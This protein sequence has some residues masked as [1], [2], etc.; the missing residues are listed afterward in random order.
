MN[1]YQK[2]KSNIVNTLVRVEGFKAYQNLYDK[3]FAVLQE[4]VDKE[5]KYKWH[6]LRKKPKDL[7]KIKNVDV[8]VKIKDNYS[9]KIYTTMLNYQNNCF[10]CMYGKVIAWKYTEEFEDEERI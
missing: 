10:Y 4:L 9:K 1:K 3:S 8:L 6:D 5:E 7:P 2:A